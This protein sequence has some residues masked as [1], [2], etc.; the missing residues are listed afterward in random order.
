MSVV[1]LKDSTNKNTI[2]A[3]Y[4]PQSYI[5]NV[6]EKSG[7]DIMNMYDK[8]LNK[9][10]YAFYQGTSKWSF[11]RCEADQTRKRFI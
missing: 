8:V 2:N 1:M 9:D 3:I 7:Q 4:F 10:K 6:D 5:D 11:V